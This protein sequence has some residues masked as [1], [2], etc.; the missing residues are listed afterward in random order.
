MTKDEVMPTDKWEF[1]KD[2]TEAF[3]DMLARSIPQYEVM[4]KAVYALAC[5]FIQPHTAVVDMGSSRG[6]AVA[7]LIDKYALK[8]R[9]YLLEV[10]EPM[11]EALQE[12]FAHYI[13]L[14]SVS[15]NN[16]DLR[17]DFPPVD[18]SVVLSILTLQFTPIEYRQ[19]I[20]RNVY[21]SLTPDGS[22]ILVEKVL[23]DTAQLDEM[24]V[25][26]YYQL[27]QL[28]GYNKEQIERKRLALEGVLVPVTASWNVELL[29]SAG[30]RKVDCFWRWCNFAGW[31]AIKD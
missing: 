27:K 26:I 7:D 29:R 2:V 11:L 24:M 25:D 18:A 15:V 5:Y 17:Q 13:N 14:N 16:C 30:F 21:D 28:N 1:D 31:I 6:E 19:Q 12:R 3:D 4:R 8:N 22:F 10:S 9:F 20:L 23:G